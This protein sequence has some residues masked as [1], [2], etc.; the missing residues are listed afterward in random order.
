MALRSESHARVSRS[1]GNCRAVKRRC[2]QRL[3][4]CGQCIRTCEECPG[5]RDEWDLVFRNQTDHTIKRSKQK[6]RQRED[7]STLPRSYSSNPLSLPELS[8]SYD[9]IGVN[10]FLCNFVTNYR[11]SSRGYLNYIPADY[12][13]DSQRSPMLVAS[14]AAIGLVTLANTTGQPQL[15]KHARAKYSEAINQVNVALASPT[16]SIKD[17]TLMTVISLGL[18]E[19]VSDFSSWARHVQ[20]AAA[21]VVARGKS[22]FSSRASFLMFNQVRADMVAVCM[23]SG[24][25]FPE[26]MLATQCTKLLSCVRKNRG[27]IPWPTLLQQAT[28]LQEELQYIVET[29]SMQS[30]Y[31]TSRKAGEDPAVFYNERF[32]VYTNSWAIRV[33]NNARILQIRTCDSMHYISNQILSADLEPVTRAHIELQRLDTQEIVSKLGKDI[34]S[35]V[36]QALGAISSASET[37]HAVNVS[38]PTNGSAGYMMTWP[39]YTAGK[40]LLMEGEARKWIIQRLQEFGHTAGI[41]LALQ[42]VENI[43]KIDQCTNRESLI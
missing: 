22:Q 38:S 23:H 42:L 25:P 24:Q 16:E 3:P 11:S 12:V 34:I 43:I 10:Y 5:Y 6:R 32:D 27:Q 21:L 31:A 9:A 18:F 4:H 26:D 29:L 33:W 35:T 28:G 17:S 1:C 41:T 15:A 40:S 13:I 2:D 36:P 19:H 7:T 20:G 14:M 8:N 39:L 37:G 30:G